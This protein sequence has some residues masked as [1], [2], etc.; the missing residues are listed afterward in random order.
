MRR[1]AILMLGGGKR[2]SLARRFKAA[3]KQRE[4]ALSL[5]AYEIDEQQPISLE[6]T[7]LVGKRWSEADVQQD[8]LDVTAEHAVDL[9][10]SH[11]DPATQVHAQ[12]RDR[13]PAASFSSDIGSTEICASKR[14][15]HEFCQASG[16][17]SIPLAEP[18][19]FPMFGKPDRGSASAGVQALHD[20][21][22]LES[23]LA[24]HRDVIVQRFV[25]G[26]EYTVDAYVS[27]AGQILGISPRIRLATIGGESV[28]TE[29]VSHPV[30]E[31]QSRDI[32][33]RLGLRGPL[34]L[35]FIADRDSE[36]SYLMEVNPRFGGGVIAS[37]EAGFD[38]PG[39][40]LDE[41]LGDPVE[42]VSSG[43][44][45]IMKRYFSEAFYAAGGRP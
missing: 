24:A 31:Q 9:I 16:I 22:E 36:V 18:G 40:M 44:R 41:L 30:I 39:M 35:Q 2:V 20:E 27:R 8:I 17:R 38:Y 42:P 15:T 25:D 4:V 10:L 5:Y 11:V 33:D 32:I 34:T 26:H 23:Y 37:I 13:H 21:A 6:A 14:R 12:L 19:V 28:V 45:L 43:R 7:V 1:I 29:T 3:A